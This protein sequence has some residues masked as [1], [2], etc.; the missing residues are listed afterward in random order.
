MPPACEPRRSSRSSSPISIVTGCSSESSRARARRI[1]TSF[2][3]LSCLR[4]CMNGGAS[5]ARR[6]GCLPVSPGCFPATA[7]SIR[8][9]ASST[10]SFAWQRG[11]PALPSVSASTHCGTALP[12]ISWSKKPISGS[13]KFCSKQRHTAHEHPVEARIYYPF[14]PRC[15]ESVL[16]LRQYAY[17]DAELVVIPQPDG[18]VAGIPAWMTH[19]SAQHHQLRAEPRLSLDILRSLRAEVDALL[20]F[21]QSDLGTENA[22]N[23]AQEPKHAA[24]PVRAEQAGRLAGPLKQRAAGSAGRSPA[25]RDRDGAGKREGRR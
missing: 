8:V 14:H 9:R 23:G 20:S 11:V 22:S 17:R 1:D 4:Y 24:G 18:S 15:G 13:S 21:L 2:S 16:I 12:L 19:E 3:R 10:G 7:G 6:A 5:R 25:A